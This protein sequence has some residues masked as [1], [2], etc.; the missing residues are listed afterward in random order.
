MDPKN[1][2]RLAAGA[3]I[4]K[5]Y[6]STDGGYNWKVYNTTS[7]YGVWGDPCIAVDTIGNFYY[8]HLSNPPKDTGNWVD[9]IV[10]QKLTS[11]S[12]TWNPGTYAGLNGTKVQDKEWSY[13]KDTFLQIY[14]WWKHMDKPC[15]DKPESRRLHGR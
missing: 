8:F 14:R 9:R 3:N 7:N 12:G 4:S 11:D 5:L 13:V 10:C 15:K 6:M 1:P 2:N